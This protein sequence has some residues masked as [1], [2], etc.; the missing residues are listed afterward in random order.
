MALPEAIIIIDD[1]I[2]FRYKMESLYEY[3]ASENIDY[4][5]IQI[6]SD[7]GIM[8]IKKPRD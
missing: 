3:V 5:I 7:D 2:K 8:I 4:K 6:D 1:V